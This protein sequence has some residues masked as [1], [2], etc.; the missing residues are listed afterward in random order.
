MCKYTKHPLTK[1]AAPQVGIREGD[2]K[3][4]DTARG[5]GRKKDETTDRGDRKLGSFVPCLFANKYKSKCT[6][7]R[8]LCRT[9]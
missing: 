2:E 8:R 3:R 7:W 1:V 5:E 6:L 9:N 4:K